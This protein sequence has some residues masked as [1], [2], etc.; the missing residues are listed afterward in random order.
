MS[1]SVE[2]LEAAW[3]TFIAG[4]DSG[5]DKI[6]PIVRES[7]N[8]CRRHAVD[9]STK[10]A[11]LEIT[12][13]A[14][15]REIRRRSRLFQA[16]QAL[17]PV[18]G[19]CLAG[20]PCLI[21]LYDNRGLTLDALSFEQAK[22]A[23]ENAKAVSGA[24]WIEREVGTDAVPTCLVLGVPVEIGASEHY[25]EAWHS[26][27]GAA[28]PVRDPFTRE[29][30]GA[31]GLYGYV[32]VPHL[33]SLALVTD[34]AAAIERELRTSLLESQLA[35][36]KKYEEYTLKSPKCGV[37][38][39]GPNGHILSSTPTGFQ[40]LGLSHDRLKNGMAI[41]DL[42]QPDCM[43]EADLITAPRELL[44]RG[45]GGERMKA[46]VLP[47]LYED[48][49]VGFL[50]ILPQAKS[51]SSDRRVDPGW[52]AR[53]TFSDIVGQHHALRACIAQAERIA[54]LDLPVLIRGETG[55]GKEL[56]AHSI[57]NA[58]SRALGPFVTVNCGAVSE[59]L[60]AA[61]LFGYSEGAFT[62]A[63]RG[64]K[65][66]RFQLADRGTLFLDEIESA[67]LRVQTHL[68]RVLEEGTVTPVGGE[69]PRAVNVRVVAA[70]NVDLTDKVK[71]GTFRQDLYYRLNCASLL[72]PPLRERATDIPTLAQI[73]LGNAGPELSAE[74]AKRLEGYCWPG[75]VRELKNIIEQS[76]INCLGDVILE[77]DLPA[78][79]CPA[80]CRTS[81]CTLGPASFSIS[82]EGGT[83]ILERTEKDAIVGLLRQF[84]GNLSQVAVYLKI[85]RST[86]YR[87]L[88]RHNI[89]TMTKWQ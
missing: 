45:R 24:R 55:T 86:L 12:S 51:T 74:A 82:S 29:L 59:E 67:S 20:A 39:I 54:E 79:L 69:K 50:A 76:I 83:S 38:A 43:I 23:A 88:K 36:F 52:R 46:E 60:L 56:F 33:R 34:F 22:R 21:G 17:L 81:Q 85:D 8:R 25:V 66:G 42:L 27:W 28:A 10:E 75:N 63:A 71:N 84:N 4:N 13:E 87:K 41:Q 26:W 89:Q 62:G 19:H 78:A 57:H 37:L 16:A 35:V 15:L 32:K 1:A 14:Q 80:P 7:W 6:R 49:S 64:G 31:L 9:P 65:A 30:I 58:S 70:T 3:R 68:L 73:F 44:L 48:R 2:Q 72:L 11:P 77:S 47:V 40:I 5:L 61:E 18:V 53:Y